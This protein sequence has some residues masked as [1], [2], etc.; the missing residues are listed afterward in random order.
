MQGWRPPGLGLTTPVQAGLKHSARAAVEGFRSNISVL[1]WTN[2]SLFMQS[3]WASTVLWGKKRGKT[4][5][6]CTKCAKLVELCTFCPKESQ[7]ELKMVVLQ[8]SKNHCRVTNCGTH[9]TALTAPSFQ[10]LLRCSSTDVNTARS[11]SADLSSSLKPQSGP[12]CAPGGRSRFGVGVGGYTP[13]VIPP[14]THLTPDS[15]PRSH[16]LSS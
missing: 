1:E 13:Q 6:L 16:T 11:T 5:F 2:Q 15:P 10:T 9:L 4:L 7:L 14:L 3:D 8:S 12:L